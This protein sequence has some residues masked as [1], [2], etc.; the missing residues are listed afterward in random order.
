MKLSVPLESRVRDLESATCCML[1]QPRETEIVAD[2]QGAGRS[3]NERVVNSTERKRGS[4]HIGFFMA[5]EE[6]IE[7]VLTHKTK[8]GELSHPNQGKAEAVKT[9]VRTT[10]GNSNFLELNAWAEACRHLPTYAKPGCPLKSRIIFA[11]EGIVAYTWK[12][13]EADGDQEEYSFCAVGGGYGTARRIP[14]EDDED[15]RPGPGTPCCSAEWK[16]RQRLLK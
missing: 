15:P 6:T 2:V 11:V 9:V 14:R 12:K 10:V 3:C 8:N 7:R 16:H 4:P 1:F 5:V 13:Q